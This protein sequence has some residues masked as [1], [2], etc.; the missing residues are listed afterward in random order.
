[1][2][3]LRKR[4]E[5]KQEK[6]L[7]EHTNK[8]G[9]KKKL[10]SLGGLWETASDLEK[11]INS[12]KDLDES[13]Q[14]KAKKEAFVAQILFHKQILKSK[15][16]KELFQQ[17]SK[18][19]AYT[20]SQFEV[21]LRAI[22]NI[23]QDFT[24]HINDNESNGLTHNPLEIT[25]EAL[26]SEKVK[27]AEKLKLARHKLVIQQQKEKL[28]KFCDCPESLVG[29]KVR[30]QCKTDSGSDWFL[31]TV[32]SIKSKN[33]DPYK[34]EFNMVYD[35]DPDEIWFFPLLRDLKMETLLLLVHIEVG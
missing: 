14:N 11:F 21:N 6:E 5:N 32:S 8:V 27:L 4:Q 3:H 16:G 20:I 10:V 35:D 22:I 7:K 25:S 9:L 29:L 24:G 28:P 2:D 33:K 12:K 31:G 13:S 26:A 34:I 15:G 23:N 30:H 18:G 19:K 1:M 17:S